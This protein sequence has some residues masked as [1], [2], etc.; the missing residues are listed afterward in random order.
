[1]QACEKL[2]NYN[3]TMEILSGLQ[4]SAIFRLKH[5]WTVRTPTTHAP[6]HTHAGLEEETHTPF[7]LANRDVLHRC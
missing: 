3:A 1:M 7:S 2:N 6:P 5:T 4:C